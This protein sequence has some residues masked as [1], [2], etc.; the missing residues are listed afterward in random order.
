[1]RKMILLFLV[2]LSFS[3]A[4]ISLAAQD[5]SQPVFGVV[6]AGAHPDAALQLGAKWERLTFHWNMFQPGGPD[7][8]NTDAISNA[9]LES[10]RA[11][12]RQVVGLI[13]DTPPWASDSG[14][15]AG[16][17]RGLDLPVDDPAN[18][19]AHFVNRLVPITAS[20]ASITG[21]SGTNL[22]FA[23][24]KARSSSRAK[25]KTTIAC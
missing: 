21:S 9:A 4:T 17:P 7:D 10:A 3:P 19:F 13:K 8:F 16:V 1:M 12:G 2:L 15:A 20:R 23:P 25:W 14:S 24:A 5:W 18:Y 11:A 6:E 22:I